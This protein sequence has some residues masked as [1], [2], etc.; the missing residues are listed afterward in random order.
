MLIILEKSYVGKY[1]FLGSFDKKAYISKSIRERNIV[2]STK[3]FQIA[4]S[5]TL[6]KT[7]YAYLNVMKKTVFLSQC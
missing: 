3:L 4:S 2:A 5:T 7:P 6:P 1:D